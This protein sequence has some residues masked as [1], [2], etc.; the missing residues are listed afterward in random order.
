MPID[1]FTVAAQIVNFFV[2]VWIL[3]RFLYRPVLE[4]MARRQKHVEESMLA[5]TREKEAAARERTSYEEQMR[6]LDRKRESTLSEATHEAEAE[7]ARLIEQAR[8]EFQSLRQRW[9]ETLRHEQ[10]DLGGELVTMVQTEALALAGQLVR[11]LADA[12]LQE[13]IIR[14]F[15]HNLEALPPEEREHFAAPLDDSGGEAV[16]RSAFDLDEPLRGEIE[17][18]ARSVIGARTPIRFETKPSLGAGLELSVNGQKT[19]WTIDNYLGSL[20]ASLRKLV[21][22]QTAADEKES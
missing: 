9:R 13:Q 7:R 21:N 6:N 5:A 10:K 16:L 17:Q 20:E 4:T 18:A 11:D 8:E 12:E 15:I 19:A 22:R 2:L 1:W 14:K 3:K